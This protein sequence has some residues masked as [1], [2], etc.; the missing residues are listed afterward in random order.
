[1]WYLSTLKT[2]VICCGFITHFTVFSIHNLYYFSQR[3][4]PKL[5]TFLA[6]P[7][8]ICPR[9]T[10]DVQTII[11]TISH[12]R[13]VTQVFTSPHPLSS[14]SQCHTHTLDTLDL[15]H[16]PSHSH[17]RQVDRQGTCGPPGIRAD[18][19]TPSFPGYCPDLRT[20]GRP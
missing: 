9:K 1:M 17:F 3:K 8:L 4:S 20:F 15:S 7:G 11:L 14:Q 13:S 10:P 18:P 16:L 2:I 6:T 12:I 5:N 19:I